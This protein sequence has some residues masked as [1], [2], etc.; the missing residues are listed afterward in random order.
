MRNTTYIGGSLLLK[1][2]HLL[3]GLPAESAASGNKPAESAEPR[4]GARFAVSASADMLELRTRTRL[5]G[6]TSDLGAGGC[7][8]DTVTPFPVGTSVVL[9]L[10]SEHHNVHA[11]A[12]VVYAHTGMGM[13]LA[14]AEMTPTQKA[15]LSAWLCELSGESPKAAAPSE[16]DM[17][18]L[19][20]A[21]IREPVAGPAGCPAGTC[22]VAGE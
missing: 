10:A 1:Q 2:E 4:K 8:I 15:N 17:P 13:G 11:M 9:N 5:N 7:Y 6:R 14:F 22:V 19:Q 16:A 20:E 18:Y 3:V 21:T 12:N